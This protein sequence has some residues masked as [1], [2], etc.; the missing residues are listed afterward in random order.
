LDDVD[1]YRAERSSDDYGDAA[2]RL[3]RLRQLY[4]GKDRRLIDDTLHLLL[5]RY[6]PT[7]AAVPIDDLFD[8]RYLQKAKYLGSHGSMFLA[9]GCWVCNRHCK[10]CRAAC[11]AGDSPDDPPWE[12]WWRERTALATLIRNTATCLG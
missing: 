4:T 11:R 2:V 8:K 5:R 12:E 7:I 1:T 6:G 9:N 3:L 10:G